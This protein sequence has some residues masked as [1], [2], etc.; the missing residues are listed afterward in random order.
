MSSPTRGR[1]H[2]VAAWPLG[3]AFVFLFVLLAAAGRAMIQATH[4][5]LVYPLDDTYIQLAI[6][7]TLAAHGGWGVT[8]H[9]FS[10]AG[11][12]LLWPWVMAAYNR[13]IGL[14]GRGPLIVNAAS[15]VL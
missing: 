4:G 7:K 5:H 3:V 10:S 8:R 1:F 13:V 14:D 12:S 6:A 15:G 9:E 2:V 11:S